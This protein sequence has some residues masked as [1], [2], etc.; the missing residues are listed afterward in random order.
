M[1][2]GSVPDSGLTGTTIAIPGSNGE[3][4]DT[5]L[6]QP[7][8]PPTG[9]AEGEKVTPVMVYTANTLIWG[10]LFT[11]EAIKVSVWLR[12]AMAP[13][14]VSIHQAQVITLGGA[15]PIKPFGYDELHIPT[16]QVIAFHIKPPDRE[17]LDYDPN[18][19]HRKMEPVTAL[20]GSFR[21]EG[22]LRMSD[23][24]NL[25]RYLDVTSES[26]T[27][28]YEVAISQPAIPSMGIIRVPMALAK[29]DV[30]AFAR[31]VAGSR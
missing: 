31:R 29:R 14:Y 2:E 24:T 5:K 10:D 12:T 4:M 21:F 15:G 11:K 6:E 9:P 1:R 16:P 22:T 8:L 7:N 28:V 19:P 27:M 26:Y 30:V 23:Q 17:P 13:Q 25:E 20:V 3:T 18:E